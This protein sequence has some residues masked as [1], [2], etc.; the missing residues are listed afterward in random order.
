M[1]EEKMA[2]LAVTLLADKNYQ[3]IFREN[4]RYILKRI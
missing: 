4:H 1:T 3:A 2:A